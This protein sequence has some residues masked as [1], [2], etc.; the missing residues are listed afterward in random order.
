MASEPKLEESLEQ[1]AEHLRLVKEHT[2]RI[3]AKEAEVRHAEGLLETAKQR[4]KRELGNLETL[5]DELEALVESPY[6][7]LPLFDPRNARRNAQEARGGVRDDEEPEEPTRAQESLP[8]PATA[9][10]RKRKE[11]TAPATELAQTAQGDPFAWKL[12]SIKQLD[13]PQPLQLRLAEADLFNLD[14]LERFIAQGGDFSA[15]PGVGKAKADAITTALLE[16]WEQ[17]PEWENDHE[18]GA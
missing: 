7:E 18:P 13:I 12:I 14:D 4:H 11:Q 1:Q 8:G 10:R 5:R 6:D 15:L 16:L 2:A 3:R 17:H 9:S